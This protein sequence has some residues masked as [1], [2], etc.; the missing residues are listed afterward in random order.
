MSTRQ[1]MHL[2]PH[3]ASLRTVIAGG[4]V[5][6]CLLL[7]LALG[8]GPWVGSHSE[9][10]MMT[11]HE[12]RQLDEIRA[13]LRVDAERRRG[14]QASALEA[15]ESRGP[16]A[17]MAEQKGPGAEPA[18]SHTGSASPGVDSAL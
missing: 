2:S 7:S 3:A 4:I 6:A 15:A 5:I 12:Y 11:E 9:P 8:G 17:P 13:L 14:E 16:A 10:V 18:P 1:R